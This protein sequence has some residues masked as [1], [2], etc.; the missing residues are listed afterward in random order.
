MGLTTGGVVGIAVGCAIAGVVIG[1]MTSAFLIQRHRKHAEEQTI[2]SHPG[3]STDPW[4]FKVTPAEPVMAVSDIDQFLLA[5]KSDKELAEEV[6]S[7]GYLIQQHVEDNYHL[8]P[9]RQ[10]AE[11]LNQELECLGLGEGDFTVPKPA[12]LAAMATDPKTRFAT[13]QHVIARVIFDSLSVKS[14]GKISML[15]PSVSS[16]VREMPPCEKHVGNSEG[17]VPMHFYS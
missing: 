13:L 2:E 10:S 7:L 4:A 5:P 3:K 17:I 16:L 6:Q 8:S 15:P 9:V 1:V 11:S 14:V 12:Q